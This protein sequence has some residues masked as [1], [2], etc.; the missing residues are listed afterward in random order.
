MTLR[1]VGA[2]QREKTRSRGSRSEPKT[3]NQDPAPPTKK[4]PSE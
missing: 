3:R 2:F 1:F 4:N